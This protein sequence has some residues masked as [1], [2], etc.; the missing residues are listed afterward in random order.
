MLLKKI[1]LLLV[2]SFWIQSGI[3]QCQPIGGTPD[4]A[5]P[6]CNNNFTDTQRVGGYCNNGEVFVRTCT[7]V[8][9]PAYYDFWASWYKFKCYQ[10]GSLGF[11]ITPKDPNDNYDWQLFDVT[12]KTPKIVFT[13]QPVGV[14]GNW[15]GTPGPTGAQT[16]GVFYNQ[17]HSSPS[18][19]AP[20]FAAMPDLIAGH[21]YLLLVCH[22]EYP[23][24]LW[25]TGFTMVFT[26]GTADLVDPSEPH[27]VA[28]STS[29][30]G[31]LLKVKFNK[32]LKC[33][34]IVGSDF[35]IIPSLASVVIPTLIGC[36][37]TYETD[38]A[39]LQLDNP[40]PPGNYSVAVVTGGDG[41]TISDYCD[42]FITE[43]E[44]VPFVIPPVQ[45]PHMDSIVQ[46][47]CMP[48]ELQLLFKKSIK[49]STIS[50]NGSQ[51]V[52]TGA[53]PVNVVSARGACSTGVNGIANSITLKLS[54]P[55]SVKGNFQV[56]LTT[57]ND[58][59]QLGDECGLTIAM[60]ETLNFVTKDTVNADFSYV[61]RLGC[62]QDT[63]DFS[64]PG[65]NEVDTWNWDFDG[66]STSTLQNPRIF[67]DIFGVRHAQLIVSNGGCSDTSSVDIKLDGKLN[68]GFETL[69]TVCPGQLVS[70]KDTS[71]GQIV[72][73]LWTFGNGNSSTLKFPQQQA[74]LIPTTT[75]TVIAK[76][77][78]QD[79]LGCTS[80]AS[81][82][83]TLADRCYVYVPTAFTPNRD[84]INDYLY[85]LN[86][87][88]ASGFRFNV[89]NRYGQLVFD[90]KD[91]SNRWDGRY[92]GQVADPG[93]YV[94]T[95]H[96]VDNHS[97]EVV[98]VSGTTILIR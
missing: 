77:S 91:L 85:P 14:S 31:G 41:N 71:V 65:G 73:R 11:V 3:A 9:P 36:G 88:N 92:K 52:V 30:S 26:G 24:G 34:T 95:L 59:N 5:L 48:V 94:W 62:K 78:L 67:Y 90:A 29:C 66:L 32:K 47:G 83:I 57:G 84:G 63:I 55:I 18:E 37:N 64:H 4:G 10:A 7:G 28:A 93:T 60:G 44:N 98:Q 97:G 89:Y 43:G 82:K 17:C 54:A 50:P 72:S 61:L 49:C 6:I 45:I 15:S 69:S 20:S 86:L 38:S 25:A 2:A 74:Y 8:V 1:I 79:N 39:T 80:V 46:P 21:N 35:K 33:S 70:F 42:R 56:K 27:I 51:F 75:T 13:V 76:L 58:G 96:Y 68:A 19:N 23:P 53:A 12:N 16:G 40:L 22:H 81:K 87:F